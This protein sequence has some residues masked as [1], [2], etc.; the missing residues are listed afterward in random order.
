M[1]DKN[2]MV[3]AVS[4]ISGGTRLSR[5]L[6]AGIGTERQCFTLGNTVYTEENSIY[7]DQEAPDPLDRFTLPRRAARVHR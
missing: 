6:E 1:L 7:D 4:R 5:E 3:I 2:Y